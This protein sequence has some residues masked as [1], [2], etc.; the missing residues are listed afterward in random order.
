MISIYKYTLV[1]DPKKVSVHYFSNDFICAYSEEV[2][3]DELS[4]GFHFC[5]I[6]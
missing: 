5:H 4:S 1:S 2:S 3:L 6:S